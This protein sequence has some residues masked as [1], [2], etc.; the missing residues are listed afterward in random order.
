LDLN[1]PNQFLHKRIAD[2]I[3]GFLDMHIVSKMGL[4]KPEVYP[5][6][7]VG[8]MTLESIHDLTRLAI[9]E[10]IDVSTMTGHNPYI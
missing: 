9:K 4:N 10:T 7:S 1:Y 8:R 5:E 6:F 2:N 3:C